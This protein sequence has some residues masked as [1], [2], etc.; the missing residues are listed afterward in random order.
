MGVQSAD[1]PEWEFSVNEVSPGVYRVCARGDG[2][3]TDE[4]TGADLDAALE[5]LKRWARRV[6]AGHSHDPSD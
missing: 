2:G 6:E 1:L 3:L 4:A 5:D